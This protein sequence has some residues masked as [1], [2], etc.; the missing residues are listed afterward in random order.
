VPVGWI[1]STS[2]DSALRAGHQDGLVGTKP[3][4]RMRMSKP[5]EGR[6]EELRQRPVRKEWCHTQE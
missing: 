1:W 4:W 3:T 2:V 6:E 5:D